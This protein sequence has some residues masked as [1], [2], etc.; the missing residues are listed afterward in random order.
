MIDVEPLISSELDRLLPP[1]DGS[2][3]DWQDVL[4]R[5]E[6]PQGRSPAQF[7]TLPR[8]FHRLP[9]LGEWRLVPLLGFPLFA[10]AIAILVLAWPF[11]SSPSVLDRAAA[12]I[13]DKPVTHVVVEDSLGTTLVNLR[14][15]ARTST[16]GR[17]EFWYDPQRGVLTITSFRGTQQFSYLTPA[18]KLHGRGAPDFLGQFVTGYKAALHSG[19]YHVVRSGTI[20]RVPVYWIASQP[21]WGNDPQSNRIYKTVTEIAISKATFKPV[22]SRYLVD[23]H[24]RPGSG[25]RVVSIETT[26]PNP[27]IFKT[28]A[29]DIHPVPP[30]GLT[31]TSPSMTLAEAVASMRGRLLA[32][33]SIGGLPRAWVG[34][35]PYMTGFGAIAAHVPGATL[36]QIPGV[37][38]FYGR[39]DYA[40]DPDYSHPYIAINEFADRNVIVNNLGLSTFPTN[41]RAILDSQWVGGNPNASLETSGLY[42]IIRASSDGNALTAARALAR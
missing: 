16:S 2:R 7:G 26:A 19:A 8:R 41:G 11:S 23:G 38:L 35:A 13:G 5:T 37:M 21:Q 28:H 6:F 10:A 18:A 42:I 25:Y 17:Q 12:A 32:P 20:G 29:K 40:G 9:R 15:G 22:Y 3:A 27:A 14:T 4:A 31:P 33:T 1:C 36:A 24:A 30:W 39:L 34:E